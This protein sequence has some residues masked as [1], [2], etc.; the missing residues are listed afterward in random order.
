MKPILERD[1]QIDVYRWMMNLQ[2]PPHEQT[3][4]EAAR[5]YDEWI[6]AHMAGGARLGPPKRTGVRVARQLRSMG[7]RGLYLPEEA[8]P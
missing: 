2:Y 5:Y 8:T 6:S 7:M 3:P 1:G 4:R